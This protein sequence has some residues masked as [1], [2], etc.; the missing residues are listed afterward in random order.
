MR[1]SLPFS[2]RSLG[3]RNRAAWN[4]ILI[5]CVQQFHE[6]DLFTSAAAMSYFGLLT[7]FP[8]LLLVLVISNRMVQGSEILA[9]IIETFPGSEEFLHATIRSLS[10]LRIGVIV[11]CAVI[12]LWAG[13]WVLSIIERA[14]NRIWGTKSRTFLQG[15]ARSLAM[16]GLVGVLL[17]LSALVTYVLVALQTQARRLPLRM[18]MRLGLLA[19]I[20]SAFWQVLFSLVSILLTVILF[21]LVYRFLPNTRVTLRNALPGALVAGLLWETAKYVFAWSLQYFHYDEIYGS[22]GA[23]VALLTWSYVSSLIL[24]FGAQLTAVLHREHPTKEPR[25]PR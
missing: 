25:V 3:V 14:L 12:V 22:V 6:N 1:K 23:V 13:T 20:G 16:I 19:V 21:A 18:L 2:R 8:V 15:R 10:N 7:L 24:L 4:T 11:S 9:Q 5:H 17:S